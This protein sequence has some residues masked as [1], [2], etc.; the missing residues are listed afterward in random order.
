MKPLAE[1]LGRRALSVGA[2]VAGLTLAAQ[3][4]KQGHKPV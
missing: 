1:K 3:P 2:D 4:R